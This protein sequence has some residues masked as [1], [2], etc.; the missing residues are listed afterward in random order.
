MLGVH[1]IEGLATVAEAIGLSNWPK[2]NVWSKMRGAGDGTAKQLDVKPDGVRPEE[3]VETD[4]NLVAI[5]E[6]KRR[7]RRWAIL[8]CCLCFCFVVTISTVLGVVAGEQHVA[9][10]LTNILNGS[11]L[12]GIVLDGKVRLSTGQSRVQG[13]GD[14]CG[15]R[16]GKTIDSSK[17]A[18]TAQ[19]ESMLQVHVRGGKTTGGLAQIWVHV[20][21]ESWDQNYAMNNDA[22][23]QGSKPVTLD[24]VQMDQVTWNIVVPVP[25]TYAFMT[26]DDRNK[27]G[28]MARNWLGAPSEGVAA[29]QGTQG[30]P[31]GGP[32]FKLS[33]I[34]V[35]ECDVIV[36]ST[37]VLWSM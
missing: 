8:S 16:S 33:S 34:F 17:D 21:E 22:V 25:G 27:D 30:G 12:T 36:E 14:T 24:D 28:K 13:E 1:A 31:F 32:D 19:C 35:G 6:G 18:A 3:S 15:I 7:R 10:D 23:F 29:S 5:T 9:M 37:I 2:E 4:G 11:N 26:L 20:C